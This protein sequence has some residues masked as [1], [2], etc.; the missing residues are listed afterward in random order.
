MSDVCV[1]FENIIKFNNN[2]INNGV[3]I[4]VKDQSGRL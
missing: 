3:N 1:F 4:C 2:Y